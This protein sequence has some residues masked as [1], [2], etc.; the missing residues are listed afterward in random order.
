ME[1]KMTTIGNN[2]DFE[3]LMDEIV[4]RYIDQGYS[5]DYIMEYISDVLSYAIEDHK[6][7]N[8]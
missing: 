2:L 8:F 3:I 5:Y 1:F 4:Q 6:R 7:A